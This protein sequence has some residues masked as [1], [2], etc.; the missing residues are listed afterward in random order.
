MLTGPCF[1]SSNVSGWPGGWGILFIS[2]YKSGW[3]H[4]FPLSCLH[5][6]VQLFWLSVSESPILARAERS[7][8][9]SFHDSR[10]ASSCGDRSRPG[11][12]P[13][14]R[15]GTAASPPAG[16]AEWRQRSNGGMMYQ[17]PRR[18]KS[19]DEAARHTG[20]G[21]GT[22]LLITQISL[23]D[24]QHGVAWQRKRKLNRNAERRTKTLKL[25]F[26]RHIMDTR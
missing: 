18:Q 8:G 2:D 19:R 22:G 24:C 13:S 14:G 21:R 20:S 11:S 5:T 10:R 7:W 26:W 15:H 6:R 3:R 25:C 4:S 16:H 9:S 12:S 17:Q 1:V 23:G